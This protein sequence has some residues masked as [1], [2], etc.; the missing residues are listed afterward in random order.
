MWGWKE[1]LVQY[2]QNKDRQRA[3]QQE[4]LAQQATN[5]GRQRDFL[6]AV[7]WSIILPGWF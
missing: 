1:I 3:A 5:A 7:L 4:R 6:G 2:E